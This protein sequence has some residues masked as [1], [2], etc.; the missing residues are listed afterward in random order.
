M[1]QL[2]AHLVQDGQELLGTVGPAHVFEH[3]VGA[4]LQRHVQ[5]RADIGGLRHGV[6]DIRSEFC[7]VRGGEPDALEALDVAA[8]AQQFRERRAVAL[9]VIVGEVHPVGVDVLPE[10][11]HLG[12]ALVHKRLDFGEDLAGPAVDLF[13]AQAGHDTERARVVA[14]HGD[15]DPAGV[16][17]LPLG[18]KDRREDLEGLHNL[19]L[20]FIFHA[21]AVQQRWQRGDVVGAKDSVHPG[22]L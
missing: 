13:A 9:H 15:R 14:A 1:W 7:R 2:L 16:G 8:G 3:L 18:G 11:G 21:C 22:G 17:G 6:D 10:Q 5:L 19:Y 20:R 4:G 12:H